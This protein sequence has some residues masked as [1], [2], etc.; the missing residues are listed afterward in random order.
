MDSISRRRFLAAMSATVASC[1]ATAV[2]AAT[3]FPGTWSPS[4]SVDVERL[5]LLG[6]GPMAD[7]LRASMTDEL[8]TVFPANIAPRRLIV[9]LTS[10]TLSSYVGRGS[11]GGHGSGGGGD[12]DYLEGEALIIGARGEI[13]SRYP[14]LLALPSSSGGAWYQPD[15][16]RA[17]I[18][19]LARSY[20]YWLSRNIPRS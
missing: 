6:Q 10:L 3:H 8:R 14:Q 20:V 18:A 15:S 7:W 2:N 11:R 1:V 17:R 4:Y 13:I 12:T 19:N 16:E 5:R 9:R